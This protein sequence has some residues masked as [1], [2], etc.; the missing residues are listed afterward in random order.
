MDASASRERFAED[1]GFLRAVESFDAVVKLF[2]NGALLGP[3]GEQARL[4][5]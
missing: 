5:S 4:S 3:A 1:G 2:A